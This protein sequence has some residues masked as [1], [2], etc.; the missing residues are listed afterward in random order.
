MTGPD[1]HPARAL[2]TLAGVSQHQE[3]DPMSQN[4]QAILA[5]VLY[6]PE[7]KLADQ[8][9]VDGVWPQKSSDTY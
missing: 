6:H 1:S 8:V 9:V 2:A 3:R 5:S 7:T 4:P